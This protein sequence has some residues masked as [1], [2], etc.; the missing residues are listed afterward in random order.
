MPNCRSLTNLFC[1]YI[2]VASYM[3]STVD[4]F[5]ADLKLM[6]S[7]AE[8]FNGPDA[9]I[10]KNA[11]KLYAEVSPAPTYVITCHNTPSP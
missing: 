10:T 7:N 5:L 8:K 2:Y 6:A 4:S 11:K 9:T 3:Y 1:I